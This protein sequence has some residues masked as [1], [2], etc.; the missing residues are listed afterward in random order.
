MIPDLEATLNYIIILKLLMESDM[1]ADEVEEKF[2]EVSDWENTG[3]EMS[4]KF[5]LLDLYHENSVAKI[6]KL[7]TKKAIYYRITEKG[8]KR[9]PKLIDEYFAIKNITDKVLDRAMKY[10]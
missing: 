4:G 1:T 9:Y 10:R 8:K 5:F 7:H 3:Y 6:Y 2:D